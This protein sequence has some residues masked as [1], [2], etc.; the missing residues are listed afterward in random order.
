[1]SGDIL[2]IEKYGTRHYVA[3]FHAKTVSIKGTTVVVNYGHDKQYTVTDV[4]NIA[5]IERTIKRKSWF[6][7]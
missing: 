5:Q 7:L 6:S 4:V 2:I 3:L 1:M